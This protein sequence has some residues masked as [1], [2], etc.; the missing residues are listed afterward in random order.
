MGDRPTIF[1]D[2]QIEAGNLW[3]D[4]LAKKLLGSKLLIAV[5]SPP[6]FTSGW[7]RAEW[8]SMEEREKVLGIASADDPHGLIY[9]V[10]FHDGERFPDKV[11]LRQYREVKPWAYPYPQFAMAP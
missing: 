1:V 2:E 8:D 6:Y 7:C 5:L 4:T 3:P 9:P 11:K 10:V